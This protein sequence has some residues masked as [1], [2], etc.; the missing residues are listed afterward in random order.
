MDLDPTWLALSMLI[1]TVG[2]ALFRYGRKQTRTP[3]I[4]AGV[5]LMVAPYF[6]PDIG[7]MVGFTFGILGSLYLIVRY[8]G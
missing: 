3:Q 2:W 6:M 4:I 5:I 1:S 8:G 7:K